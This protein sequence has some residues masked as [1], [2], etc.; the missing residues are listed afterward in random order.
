MGFLKPH[1]EKIYAVM[2]IFAG[3]MFMAHGLQKIFGLFGG[4]P[5]GAPAFI[6][7]GAGA[8]ELVTGAL[9]AIGLVTA[10]AAFLASGT[11]AFAYF[12][13]HVMSPQNPTHNILPI[14]NKGELAVL[15]CWVFLFVAAKGSGIWSV[16]ATRAKAT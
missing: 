6:V 9:I 16:D 2:R 8:I 5:E 14:V 4:V 12:L 15:Y 7:Y 10:P 3:L 11:M 13:G 1:A